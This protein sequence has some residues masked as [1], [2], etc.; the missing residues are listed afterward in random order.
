MPST[1]ASTSPLLSTKIAGAA[2]V[3]NLVLGPCQLSSIVRLISP[4]FFPQPK[5]APSHTHSSPSLLPPQP[6]PSHT[7]LSPLTA[8]TKPPTTGDLIEASSE[9][10]CYPLS[11][12]QLL[13]FRLS[14]EGKELIERNRLQAVKWGWVTMEGTRKAKASHTVQSN[15]QQSP[16]PLFTETAIETIYGKV[17]ENRTKFYLVAALLQVLTTTICRPVSTL[18]FFLNVGFQC[19]AVQFK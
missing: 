9:L 11:V 19:A 10:V 1:P 5:L 2:K 13:P 18:T 4:F 7:N 14:V 16:H 15:L 17:Y 6:I 3:T 8:S 12:I